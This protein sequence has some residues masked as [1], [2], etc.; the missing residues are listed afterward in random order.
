VKKYRGNQISGKI[1]E[2]KF[3]G[4]RLEL[5]EDRI[6]E[7]KVWNPSSKD[8]IFLSSISSIEFSKARG[9]LRIA[10]SGGYREWSGALFDAGLER[11]TKQL[12]DQVA[13]SRQALRL[14]TRP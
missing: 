9:K 10:F 13:R 6:V 5:H 2:H 14:T 12:R 1:A 11:F 3:L 8:E 4:M 7:F